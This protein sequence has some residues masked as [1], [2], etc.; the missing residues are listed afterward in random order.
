MTTPVT[1]RRVLRRE[2]RS[3]RTLPAVVFATAL[4]L[5]LL[6]AVGA[7]VAW[8]LDP[9][10]KAAV[11]AAVAGVALVAANPAVAIG[12]GLLA[13]ALAVVL[14]ALA[15]APGR[16]ARRARLTPRSGV[17]VDDG[18][19]ADAI[20]DGVARRT[21]VP[22]G[23]VAVTIG[24]RTA[25]VRLTPTSGVPVDPQAGADAAAAVLA[26]AGFPLTPRVHVAGEGV[27]G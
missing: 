12:V 14:L 4:L 19:L 11:D 3:S 10:A 23:R 24:R 18:V 7:G 20:A 6:I 9:G 22:R 27:I 21:G 5:V 25:S 8:M 13:T 15:F 1:S 16:R 26:E 17:I 2:T